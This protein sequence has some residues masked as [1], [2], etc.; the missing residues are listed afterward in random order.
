MNNLYSETKVEY[1]RAVLNGDTNKEKEYLKKL[2]N[3]GKRIKID[4]KKYEKELQKI[5]SSSS[6]SLTSKQKKQK[7]NKKV[8]AKTTYS[9]KSVYTKDNSIII[10]F[11]KKISKDFIKFYESKTRGTYR[12]TFDIKGRFK[13]TKPI[14]LNLN[15]IDKITISQYKYNTLRITLMNHKNP[16]TIYIINK[17]S[18]KIK[19]LEEKTEDITK[20]LS[21]K[22]LNISRVVVL[23]AGH[24]GKDAGAVGPKKRLEKK[25][26]LSVTKYT[27]RYLKEMGYKV[28]LTRNNDKFLK[29]RNRTKY[30]N[31]K[32]ADIFISFHANA[33]PRSKIKKANGIETYFLS[34]ARS[35]RAKRVAALEN[36]NDMRAM[37]YSSK[38]AF[39][40]SLNR[41]RITASHKL[42]IDIHSNMLYSLKKK[43]S[44]IVDGGVREGPFWILVGAQMPSV[45]IELGYIS[46]PL[47]SKRLYSR[48]YQKLLGKS[49]ANGIN[50]YFLKNQ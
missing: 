1:L 35:E 48:S 14:K 26:V 5:D 11:N 10:K 18:I 49:I 8:S 20:I 15:T 41:P 16:K 40:E 2:I 21:N 13:E 3:Y 44:D 24:G 25:V 9:I 47:E 30:A 32:N 28:Y 6:K 43:Y 23:D 50:A 19:V 36:K 7:T 31:K 17:D 4:V 27:S 34:P 45:L 42:A 37:S 46:H 12:D 33:A 22:K 29:L 38:N 39:L